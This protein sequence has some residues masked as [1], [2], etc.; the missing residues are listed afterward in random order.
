MNDFLKGIIYSISYF[1]IIPIQNKSFEA[2]KKFYKGVIFGLPFVGFILAIFLSALYI[3]LTNIMPSWYAA[4]ISSIL[5]LFSYG[6]IHLEAV[7]DTIDGWYASLSNK[8]TYEVMK[9][10]QAG[11][12]GAIGTFCFI[13][14]KVIALSVLLLQEQYIFIITALILS[15][16]SIL[17]A[18][19]L[20][21]HEKSSFIL[22]MQD[23]FNVSVLLKL[24][25]LPINIL[26]KIILNK[27]KKRIGFLNGDSL[28]FSIELIEIILLNVAII[29]VYN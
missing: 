15:R 29:I 17:F 24:I 10:P 3:L 7:S 25:F 8:D 21:F 5:Y 18:L 27:I 2:N 26:S 4:I 19:D 20:K 6:F 1:S 23:S 28:G 22:S 9:E 11:A 14:L 12:I 13:L 16:L